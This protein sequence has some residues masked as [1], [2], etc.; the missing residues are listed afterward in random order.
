MKIIVFGDSLTFGRAKY[1]VKR[2]D[3]WPYLLSRSLCCELYFRSIPGST[4]MDVLSEVD[5]TIKYYYTPYESES[6]EEKFDFAIVHAGIVDATPRLLRRR[7]H[8]FFKKNFL[9]SKL[10]RTKFLYQIIGKPWYKQ[11]AFE[12]KIVELITKLQIIS[13]NY[14]FVSVANP[15]G[16]LCYN[17]GDFSLEVAKLNNLLFK[18]TR[19]NFIVPYSEEDYS[20]KCFL[21]DGA[22]LNLYGQKLVAQAIESHIRTSI[23]NH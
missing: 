17:T 23:F 20:P 10:K 4:L 9:Y 19:N 8:E 13:K 18:H 14:S 6:V 15:S 21:P 11:A 1:G 12:K 22:H 7:L 5:S 2:Y 3:T 16:F